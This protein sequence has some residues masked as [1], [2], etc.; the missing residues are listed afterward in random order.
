MQPPLRLRQSKC[1]ACGN[2]KC[3][4]AP[5]RVCREMRENLLRQ[6]QREEAREGR[7]GLRSF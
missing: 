4:G 6:E 3:V 2:P 1:P 7:K 5:C